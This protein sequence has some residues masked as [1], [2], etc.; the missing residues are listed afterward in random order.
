MNSTPKIK[1]IPLTLGGTVYT[2]PPATIATLEVMSPHLDKVN[3]V[4]A[5]GGSLA[6]SDMI[7]VADFTAACLQ[8]NYPEITREFVA[9]H[10]GLE[11]V[12]EVMQMCLDTSG[13]LRKQLAD[14]VQPE[15]QDPGGNT[16][17]ESSG[18]ASLPKS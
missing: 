1:G 12:I 9:Q 10:V 14:Q 6:L 17:G 4:F 11:N 5:Q 16:L 13:M 18:T 8:R 2:L 7:F 3:A 15:R